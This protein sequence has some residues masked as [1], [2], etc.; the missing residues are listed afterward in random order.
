MTCYYFPAVILQWIDT[1]EKDLPQQSK[2]SKSPPLQL[3]LTPEA[4][5]GIAVLAVPFKTG[6]VG[7]E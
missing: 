2:I 1:D 5:K 4:L 7:V 6:C 3:Y